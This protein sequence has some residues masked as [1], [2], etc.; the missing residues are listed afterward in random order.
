MARGSGGGGGGGGG[1]SHKESK[2]GV[3]FMATLVMWGVSVFFEILFNKRSELVPIIIGFFFFL[4]ANV[5]V[6]NFVSRDP[7][8]VNT[9]VSLLHSSITSASGQPRNRA[10]K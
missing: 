5:V 4:S 9:S 1:R 7:L 10:T 2:A 8:F 3:F 6:R